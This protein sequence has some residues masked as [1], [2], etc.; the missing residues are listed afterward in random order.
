L[1]VFRV[2]AEGTQEIVTLL[3]RS[4]APLRLHECAWRAPSGHDAGMLNIAMASNVDTILTGPT[5]D[6]GNNEIVSDAAWTWVRHS[7]AGE[8]LAFALIQGRQLIIDD[9]CV[10]QTD[11]IGDHVEELCAASVA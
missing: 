5:L 4:T 9:K 7:L 2:N 10:F 6:H 11:N 8:L 3:A 1:S